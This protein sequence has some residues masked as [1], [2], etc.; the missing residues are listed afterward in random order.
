MSQRD[1]ALVLDLL[2]AARLAVEFMGGLAQEAFDGDLK[3]QASVQHE[4]MLLGEG[5]KRLSEEFR[6]QHPEVPWRAIAG[7]RDNLIH[8]YDDVDLGEVWRTVTRDV[9][10][11]IRRLEPLAPS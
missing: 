5:V 11:L 4:L 8:A 6:R 9:P 3:T 2:R 10:A 1:E 7:M